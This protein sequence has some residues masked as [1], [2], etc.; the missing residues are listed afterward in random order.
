LI[1][2]VE[3]NTAIGMTD[4]RDAS[5]SDMSLG[6]AIKAYEAYNS[7]FNNRLHIWF[8][9]GTPRG[10]PVSDF[11]PI[12]EAAA[13]MDTGITMHCA[14]APA[15][16]PLFHKQYDCSPIQFCENAKLTS[17]KTVLAHVVHLDAETDYPILARTGT[18]ASHNP[19]SNCKL[20]SGIAAVPDMLSSGVNV[21]L[22]TDGAPCN[23]T[24]DMIREMHLTA[25]L[26]AGARQEAGVISAYKALEMATINGA[27][28]L[29]LEQDIGSLEVGKKADFVIINPGGLHAAPWN[30]EQVIEGGIDPVTIVVH[31]CSG[32]DV[33][34]V[35]VD[36]L[37]LVRD[38]KL[39]H[40]DELKLLTDAKH[41]VSGIR[42]RSGVKA[43]NVDNLKYL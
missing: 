8:A 11:T 29:G 6:S 40:H 31:S 20:G 4:A 25:I 30:A 32:Q 34:T 19:S 42:S 27:R 1:K 13:K 16:N 35:V 22:G 7:S 39:V 33:D 9:A 14:E 18:T 26:H 37:I 28:A 24:Y 38:G 41:A 15:D 43:R 2:S 36:G 23:N 12:G 21:A 3:T 17:R 5:V 10:A